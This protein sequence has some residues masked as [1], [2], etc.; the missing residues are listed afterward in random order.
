MVG[1]DWHIIASLTWMRTKRQKNQEKR[2]NTDHAEALTSTQKYRHGVRW[3]MA[4]RVSPQPG[5]TLRLTVTPPYRRS[6]LC[7]PPPHPPTIMFWWNMGVMVQHIHVDGSSSNSPPE[8]WSQFE[9]PTSRMWLCSTSCL[10]WW[11]LMNR[12]VPSS[13]ALLLYML[14]LT[15]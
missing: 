10:N 4:K 8:T 1:E 11:F 14:V 13:D 9:V 5:P 15:L 12:L 3:W 2:G 6:G 7:L